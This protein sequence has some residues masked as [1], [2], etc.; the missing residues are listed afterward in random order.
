MFERCSK[1]DLS[2]ICGNSK[3]AY[4]TLKTN[5]RTYQSRAKSIQDKKGNVLT[6]ND[7]VTKMMVKDI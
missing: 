1:F 5:T 2:M 7:D 6:G 3:I 4:G